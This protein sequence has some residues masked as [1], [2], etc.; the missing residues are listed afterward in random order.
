MITR[1]EFE[2]SPKFITTYFPYYDLE[3]YD[4][5]DG[6]TRYTQVKLRSLVRVKSDRDNLY[7]DIPVYTYG[8]AK[9]TED[10]YAFIQ[11]FVHQCYLTSVLY[12]VEPTLWPPSHT[13][14]SEKER[15]MYK[16]PYLDESSLHK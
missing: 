16:P 4:V 2:W 13:Q 6:D 1:S 9:K 3:T 5:V 10:V 7:Y 12:V 15:L 8:R 14:E 11:H